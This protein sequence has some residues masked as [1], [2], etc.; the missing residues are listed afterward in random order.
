[1]Y[2]FLLDFFGLLSSKKVFLRKVIARLGKLPN[3]VGVLANMRF[4]ASMLVLFVAINNC[5]FLNHIASNDSLLNL[6][7]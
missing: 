6:E 3:N 4:F 2:I 5:S 7:V 1:M